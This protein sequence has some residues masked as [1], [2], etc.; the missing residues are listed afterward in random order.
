[1]LWLR[2]LGLLAERIDGLFVGMLVKADAVVVV[3]VGVVLAG[4]V[5]V[6]VALVVNALLQGWT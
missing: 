4:V 5:V 1:V 2:L 3:L 6:A